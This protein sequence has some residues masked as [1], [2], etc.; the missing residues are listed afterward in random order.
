MHR[1]CFVWALVFSVTIAFAQEPASAITWYELEDVE[2]EERYVEEM[3]DVVMFPKFRPLQKALNG[4]M[5]EIKGYIIPVDKEGKYII[6]SAYPYA[7]CFFC[8]NASP[9]SVMTVRLK[10]PNKKYR[11]DSFRRFRGR[12]RLNATDMKELYYILE[13]AVETGRR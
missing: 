12:L 9:A 11:T 1:G 2:L 3:K 5:V 13:E 4:T 7:S 8:G 6:L 10:T